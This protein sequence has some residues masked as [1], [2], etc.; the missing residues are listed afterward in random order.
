MQQVF[1]VI[2]STG[3]YDDHTEWTVAAYATEIEATWHARKAEMW[4]DANAEQFREHSCSCSPLVN[5]YDE[6]MQMDYSGTS[7][8]VQG[9]L[10]ILTRKQ[11]EDRVKGIT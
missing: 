7:Y 9:P 1:I 5:P 10:A 6:D 2:G 8:S 4:A 11:T 3:E